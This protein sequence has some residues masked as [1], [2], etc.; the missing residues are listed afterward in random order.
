MPARSRIMHFSF[1]AGLAMS[2]LC[3]MPGSGQ[4]AAT[5]T[6]INADGSDE[7]FNDSTAFTA[8]G[9]NYAETLGQA[10]LN[11]FQYAANLLAMYL[12]SSVEIQIR[13]QINPLGGNNPITLGSAAPSVVTRDFTSAPQ[14]NTW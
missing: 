11:T 1:I 2:L 7:G 6:I 10:R 14:A 3:L 4:A 12:E 9:G 13:A 5:I 8:Q